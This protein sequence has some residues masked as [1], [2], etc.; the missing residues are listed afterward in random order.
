MVERN[1]L[2]DLIWKDVRNPSCTLCR[3]HES[4]Q[5]VCLLGDG[6]VPCDSMI[7]G[8]APGFREDELEI[9][10]S[11]KAGKLLRACLKDI[12]LNPNNIYIT[13]TVACR[14]PQNR[15]PGRSEVK[16]CSSN[17]L[18]PQIEAVRPKVVLVLGNIALSFVLGKKGT[19]T[20]AEGN[21]ITKDGIIYVP[22]RHPSSVARAYDESLPG[23]GPEYK[24]LVTKFKENLL[25]F[26]RILEPKE[27]TFHYLR[28]K[29]VPRFPP[30]PITV[31]IETTSLN[32]FLPESR[33]HSMAVC[34]NPDKV[35]AWKY[36]E[37]M[38]EDIAEMIRKHPIIAQR[39]TF[40]GSWIRQHIGVP[41]R[42]HFDT[43]IGSYVIDENEQSGLKYQAIK[44][45]GVEPWVEE[46]DFA[47]PDMEV[48]LPYNARDTCYEE[49]LYN[50]RDVPFL[51]E[52]PKVARLLKYIVFPAIEV[53]SDVIWRGFHIDEES[54]MEKIGTC[55]EKLEYWGEKIDEI[56]GYHVNPGSPKQMTRLLYEELELTCPVLT[57]K[58]AKSSSEAALIRLDNH[59]IVEPALEWRKYKKYKSTYLLPWVKKGPILHA[60]YGFSDTDTGRLNSTMVATKRGEKKLGAN[61][62]QCPRDGFIRNL[63]TARY[64]DWV[65]V[66]ADWSQIELRLVAH[67]SGDK[68]MTEI[69]NAGEDIHYATAKTLVRGKEIDKETRKRAKAVNFGFVYGMFPP[70]FRKYAKEKFSLDIS[71]KESERF[72]EAFFDKYDGLIPWHKKVESW[73]SRHGYIDSVFGR[74]RHLPLALQDGVSCPRCHGQPDFDSDCLFCGGDG[75]VN[76]TVDE[77]VKREAI[78]QG[79]NS[80]IQSAGS[81][82]DLFTAA[83]IASPSLSWSFKLDDNKAFIVGAAHDSLIFECHRRYVHALKEGLSWTVANL[84]T[85][86]YFGFK[87]RVPILMDIVAYEDCWEGKV[88]ES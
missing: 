72:R 51:K 59:P 80:P 65:V 66:V 88:L 9:P 3:L 8:E 4:A 81:D 7:I 82:L 78:R 83:L 45:L 21:P 40:E 73:V 1:P 29:R 15:T 49:R 33:I 52:N 10:F 14:P 76:N 41:I 57:K 70:K 5:T 46:M 62:H 50:E 69:F 13:N 11:G 42:V 68:T 47:N 64:P 19:I 44:V 20:K 54:A 79:I 63:I 6:P 37:S 32:P 58:G 48:L 16:I 67:E 74:R 30:G 24:Y 12:G 71:K 18:V 43:K 2:S 31:D 23:G 22:C 75:F 27:D 39:A 36:H 53:F 87:F 34:Q 17:Y 55:D 77:W 35:Y 26:K 61:L 56:A 84:P 85:Q 86:K 25:L 60:N 38:K 28:V